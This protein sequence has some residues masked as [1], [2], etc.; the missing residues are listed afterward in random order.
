[1]LSTFFFKNTTIVENVMRNAMTLDHWGRTS[2]LQDFSI[3]VLGKAQSYYVALADF[4]TKNMSAFLTAG[5]TESP[6]H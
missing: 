6:F 4:T 1:M 2:I 3:L 5:E